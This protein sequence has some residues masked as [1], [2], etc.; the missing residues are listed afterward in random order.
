[1][2]HLRGNLV[3]IQLDSDEMIRADAELDGCSNVTNAR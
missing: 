2:M 1:M 3:V